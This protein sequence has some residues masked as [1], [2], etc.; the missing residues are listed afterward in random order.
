M[1]TRPALPR[2]EGIA[3]KTAGLRWAVGVALASGFLAGS[4]TGAASETGAGLA[5][6]LAAGAALTAG[7]LFRLLA[8]NCREM[9]LFGIVGMATAAASWF[10][11]FIILGIVSL[12]IAI[13]GGIAAAM[14]ARWWLESG[15][16]AA[17]LVGSI[18][19]IAILLAS[20]GVTIAY[21]EAC[22]PHII[23]GC[24][25][26]PGFHYVGFGLAAGALPALAGAVA[27]KSAAYICRRDDARRGRRQAARTPPQSP[28]HGPR[29]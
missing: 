27:A 20:V 2:A 25:R 22:Q 28:Y 8:G 3:A 13:L 9:M 1:A 15:R 26:R 10:L 7:V 5:G 21:W 19:A 18:A 17:W 11:P 12:A 6:L 16:G 14:V 24:M 23:A 4:C 29:N